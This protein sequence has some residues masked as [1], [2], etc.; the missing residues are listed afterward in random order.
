MFIQVQIKENIN[1]TGLCQGNSPVTGEFPAE[2]P[3]TQKMFSFDDVMKS[4]NQ[5]VYPII[6]KWGL[7]LDI[8]LGYIVKIVYMCAGGCGFYSGSFHSRWYTQKGTKPLSELKNL[9]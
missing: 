9:N 3:V 7:I 6:R 5:R 4:G 1:V 2:G 8:Q